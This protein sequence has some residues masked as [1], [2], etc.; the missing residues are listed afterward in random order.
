[1]KTIFQQIIDHEI[2]ADI[3]YE[4]DWCLAFKDI[5]P[6]A[7][8][9][10]LLVPKKAIQSLQLA[11]VEDKEVISHLMTVI[12]KIAYEQELDKNGYRVITN[13]GNDGGQTVYHLH[14]HIIGG[15]SMQW[16]PG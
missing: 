11:S 7:P 16:P 9:H 8:K 1:M 10:F 14:F 6:V 2:L 13:I 3:I 5:H 15:R 12:P 4:D